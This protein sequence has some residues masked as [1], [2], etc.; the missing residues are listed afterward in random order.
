MLSPKQLRSYQEDGIVFPIRALAPEEAARFRRGFQELEE[1]AQAPQKYCAYTHLFFPLLYELV[2]H[3]VVVGGA[4]DILG[5]DVLVDSS[6]FLCKH[7]F[8]GTYAPWHQ[9]G[10]YSLMHTTPSVS[11]WIA[12]TGSSRENGCMRVLP[13]SHAEGRRS[14]RMVSDKK[15]LF[16]QSPE[17]ETAVEESLAVDVELRAGE[18][19]LHDSS[20][21][22]G[23]KPNH[24]DTH[25]LG[26]VIRF[27]TPSF[28]ARKGTFPV[29]R[30][31]GSAH[32]EHFAVLSE[33]PAG[34]IPDCFRR[35]RAACPE[36]MPRGGVAP[37]R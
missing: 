14:H 34:A 27:I 1:Q 19:S 20:I 31:L 7:P 30:A 16:D 17:I 36:D 28:Q 25:R 3:P 23:S 6:L 10:V 11:A 15:T 21:V 4:A 37:A 22:H 18:M 33:P 5:S 35:W 26:F 9:D 29:V 12:L 24:S 2:T 32:C 8:D 13:G